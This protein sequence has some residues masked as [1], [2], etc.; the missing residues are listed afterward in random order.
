M[1]SSPLKRCFTF[2]FHIAV[3]NSFHIYFHIS[4]HISAYF[5]IPYHSSHSCFTFHISVSH[6][7]VFFSHLGSHLQ[8]SFTFTVLVGRPG[9]TFQRHISHFSL[10]L[11]MCFH[12]CARPLAFQ[13]PFRVG[14]PWNTFDFE[15]VG[16][17]EATTDGHRDF[18]RP[19]FGENSTRLR[20]RRSFT[21][22]LKIQDLHFLR[23]STRQ[24]QR[25]SATEA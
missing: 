6:F 8:F 18:P 25:R 4:F 19:P 24:G 17:L 10:V 7:S 15:N 9:F 12:I 13:N 20:Q 2:R 11:H 23:I 21:E 14:A 3:H 16:Q 5:H 1:V 22:I